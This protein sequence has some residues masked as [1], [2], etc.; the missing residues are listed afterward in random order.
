MREFEALEPMD[1]ILLTDRRREAPP[2]AGGGEPGKAGRNVLI[3]AGTERE[4]TC[5]AR[6]RDAS[7]RATGCASR[8]PAAAAYGPRT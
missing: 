8:P 6:P 1:F 7:S 3:A 4:R 5:P 2:G